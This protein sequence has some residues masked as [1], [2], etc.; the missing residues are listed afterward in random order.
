MSNYWQDLT[1]RKARG[2]GVTYT[3]E[4]AGWATD[5]M[6]GEAMMLATARATWLKCSPPD[7]RTRRQERKIVALAK[8]V[9]RR[10]AARGNA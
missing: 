7:E 2:L 9:E 3:Q 5:T 1:E 10:C 6:A 4:I 8:A